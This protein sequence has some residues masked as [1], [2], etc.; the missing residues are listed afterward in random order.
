GGEKME[1]GKAKG[2]GG[3]GGA[4]GGAERGGPAGRIRAAN[5]P[6]GNRLWQWK[7]TSG[8]TRLQGVIVGTGP[9]RQPQPSARATPTGQDTPVPWSGQYP[10]GFLLSDRYCWLIFNSSTW[11]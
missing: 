5:S 2:G 4:G 1:G 9:L 7:A 3:G 11:D 8:R 6:G 10:L